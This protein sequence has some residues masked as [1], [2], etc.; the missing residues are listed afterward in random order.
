MTQKEFDP[1]VVIETKRLVLRYLDVKDSHAIFLNINNDKEVLKYFLDR[2]LED[3]TLMTIKERVKFCLENKRY[4]F[5]MELKDTNEVIGMIFQCSTPEKYFN[6]SE[7]GYAIGRNYWNQGYAT[8]A[9]K[10]MIDFVFSVGVNKVIVSHI[11]ENIASKKVIEKCGLIYES[12]R[13]EDIYYH[14]KYYDVDYY[15]LL[16]PNK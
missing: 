15:Y 13:K 5:V 4:F 3:E 6:N 12:R 16:N 8:E 1:N 14:D 9:L 11:V 7:I 2:Y 10:A